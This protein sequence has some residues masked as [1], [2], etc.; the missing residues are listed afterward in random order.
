VGFNE[1]ARQTRRG[2]NPTMATAENEQHGKQ[3]KGRE[4]ATG[5]RNKKK[6]A[7]RIQKRKKKKEQE[8]MLTE[9]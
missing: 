9:E 2:A 3:S 6:L 5:T 7:R 4:G 1:K 8:N